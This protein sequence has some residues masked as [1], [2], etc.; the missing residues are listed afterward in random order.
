MAKIKVGRVQMK[1][2]GE[3][4]DNFQYHE[5]DSVL[6]G[7]SSYVFTGVPGDMGVPDVEP[8]WELIAHSGVVKEE[9]LTKYVGPQGATGSQGPKGDKG[10]KG[11]KGDKGDKG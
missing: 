10:D 5:L 7:G 3:W 4:K 8:F 2:C 11:P 1:F 6:W 9:G